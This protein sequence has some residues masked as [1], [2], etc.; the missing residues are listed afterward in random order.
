MRGAGTFT[1]VKVPKTRCSR[2]AFLVAPETADAWLNALHSRPR[3]HML[4]APWLTDSASQCSGLRPYPRGFPYRLCKKHLATRW[5][6]LAMGVSIISALRLLY[7]KV[8]Q[9][10]QCFAV[11][12]NRRAV[13]FQNR[14]SPALP[15]INWSTL[16]TSIC[17][18]SSIKLARSAS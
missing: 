17:S 1:R 3:L 8:G 9:K 2:R 6:V 13:I 14:C 15:A 5:Q 18:G 16:P 4:Q 11:K 10:F 7:H 12:Q